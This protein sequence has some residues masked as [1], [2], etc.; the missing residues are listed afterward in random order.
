MNCYEF[1]NADEIAR[2][3][4]PFRPESVAF[5][6]GRI[7]LSR[8]EQL[9]SENQSFAV[10]TTLATKLYKN[11]IFQA[12]KKGY[13]V[14]LLF[15]WLENV[16]IAVDRVRIRVAEGGHNFPKDVIIR[17]YY[18][19]IKNLLNIYMSIVDKLIIFDNSTIISTIV[20][21]KIINS[22]ILIHQKISLIN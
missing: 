17:R 6:A 5:E 4:S 13:Q 3:L 7:M 16:D 12:S 18:S 21:E 9:F 11:K 8:I 20:A 19:G 15:F 22:D 1:V 14:M 10:E 2:G